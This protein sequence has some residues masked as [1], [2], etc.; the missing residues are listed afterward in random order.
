M[1]GSDDTPVSTLDPELY[2]NSPENTWTLNGLDLLHR[3]FENDSKKTEHQQFLDLGCGTGGFT[4]DFLLPRC[5]PFQRMVAVDVSEDM[6]E[7][8]RKNSAHPKISYDVLDV[9]AD[10][11]SPFVKRYGRF[12]RVYSFLLFNWLRDHDRAIKNVAELLKPGGD[13]IILFHA[14]SFHMRFRKKLAE[15]NRWKKYSQVFESCLPPTASM[16]GKEEL[17]S[18]MTNLLKTVN[19]TLVVCDVLQEAPPCYTSKAVVVDEMIAVNP[20]RVCVGERELPLL[21]EDIEDEASRLWDLK[22]GTGANPFTFDLLVVRATK[23][24]AA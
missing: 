9:A 7:Y 8:A 2:A 20:I 18:Y 1:P 3:T 17:V 21:L 23:E 5:P 24:A 14:T 12:D 13:C 22:R 11:L 10:D 19:L 4:R 16:A 6:I 15:T